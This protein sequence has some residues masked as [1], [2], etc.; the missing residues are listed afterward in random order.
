MPDYKIKTSA[1]GILGLIRRLEKIENSNLNLNKEM[2]DIGKKYTTKAQQY[3]KNSSHTQKEGDLLA[4][5]IYYTKD[6]NSITIIAGMSPEYIN[7]LYY[8]EFGAGMVDKKHPLANKTGWKYDI[9]KH[10]T[11]GWRF[12]PNE[13]TK[14]E[15]ID[16]KD[17][18]YYY[19]RQESFKYRRDNGT[20][21][22][23]VKS[24]EP[25]LFMYNT[26]K[27]ILKDGYVAKLI[28]DKIE[29]IKY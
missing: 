28:K 10:G 27:D 17:A 19:L 20:W 4:N 3:L 9:K 6:N 26:H 2:D 5:E 18:K 21:T 7:A 24:S 29:N 12:T 16:G 22:A 11:S 8:A 15:E 13:N 23:W 14:L 25:S 1:T